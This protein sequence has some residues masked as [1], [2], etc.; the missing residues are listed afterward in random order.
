MIQK[1]FDDITK[2]DVDA[3]IANSVNE[4]KTLEYKQEL[5]GNTDA[6]RKEFLADVSSFANAS[7]GDIL[8][9]VKAAVND[10]GKATGAPEG[11]LPVGDTTADEA[12]LRLEEIVRNGISPRL[13]VQ[14][15]EIEGWGND[16][17]GFVVLLRIPNSFA[18]PHVVSFKGGSRFYSRN[19]AGKYPLDVDELR[20]AFLAT[21]S[22]AERIKQFRQERL[23]KIIADETPVVLS[24]PHRLVLHVIPI[25]SFLNN[26][27]LD[28]SNPRSFT[29]S[30]RLM[31][32]CGGNHR[33][34][35]DGV[36][37]HS[38]DTETVGSI[39]Q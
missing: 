4:S 15:R 27:R 10:D 26:Q 37:T 29:T 34:N 1:S 9:G 14:I 8:F 18:S 39:S 31:A 5:P 12:K 30:C 28:L 2:P 11:V 16:G 22:Q 3:L 19:S 7:G 33:Y 20:S 23:G 36:L 38:T 35:L 25:A 6:N 32:S 21:D 17:Q 13:P 24:T